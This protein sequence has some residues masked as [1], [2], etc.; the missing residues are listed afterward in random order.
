MAALV[1]VMAYTMISV[2][3]DTVSAINNR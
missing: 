3:Y 1:G 2:I